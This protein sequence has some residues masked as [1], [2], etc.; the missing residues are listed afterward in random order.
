MWGAA[1][2]VVGSVGSILSAVSG[3]TDAIE[4]LAE[5]DGG[6]H[7][8]EHDPVPFAAA[9]AS[10]ILGGR[11]GEQEP[12]GDDDDSSSTDARSE[13][14]AQSDGGDER[15]DRQPE[16]DEPE[17][18]AR[19]TGTWSFVVG[20]SD[21]ENVAGTQVLGAGA[22]LRIEVGGSVREVAGLARLEQ[23]GGNR[24]EQTDGNK[25]EST[26]RYVVVATE[27]LT[28][29]SGA[30]L[31]TAVSGDAI[32][33]I[34]GA[35]T[36]EGGSTVELRADELRFDATDTVVFECGSARVSISGDGIAIEGT[37]IVIRG[38][39]IGVDTPALG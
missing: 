19:G 26:G 23:V 4:T 12:E 32:L 34:A 37:E 10:A 21:Q 18:P 38:S 2:A 17:H 20:G 33:T 7:P 9:F 36:L 8:Y 5:A 29:T 14:S 30:T 28:I 31:R 27:G 16:E 3:Q 11:L 13:E 15:S 22:G 39:T 6:A 35:H 1:N 25:T 24:L